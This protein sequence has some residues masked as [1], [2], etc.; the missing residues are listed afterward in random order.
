MFKSKT[1]YRWEGWESSGR[2]SLV[3]NVKHP[4]ELIGVHAKLIDN[5]LEESEKV[6]YCIYAPRISST[7]TS[8]GLKSDESSCGI[9]V[10]DGRFI[11]SKNRHIKEHKPSLDSINFNDVLYINFG[12]VMLLSWFSITYICEG[13]LKQLPVLFASNGRRYFEKAIRSYKKYLPAI[14]TENF[15]LDSFTTAGFI[16]KIADTFHKNYLKSLISANERCVLTFSCR[17]LWSKTKKR[18]FFSRKEE[19]YYATS[20]ATILLTNKALLFARDSLGF[21]VGNSV[22]VLNIPLEKIERIVS[23]IENTPDLVIHTLKIY[24][25]TVTKDNA[26]TISLISQKEN[27]EACVNKI[28]LLFKTGSK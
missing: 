5:E 23:S 10:T 8:F 18:K 13:S 25:K 22:D 15:S 6:E 7:S 1:K 11:V 24:F 17:Y 20:S 14:D 27:I 2:E 26:L 28:C 12:G 9:C 4:C 21:S 19:N 16:Y 3:F